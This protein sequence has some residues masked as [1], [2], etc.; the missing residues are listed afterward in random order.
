MII[1]QRK[2]ALLGESSVTP[3]LPRYTR[4]FELKNR[5]FEYSLIEASAQE[6][7]SKKAELSATQATMSPFHPR[8]KR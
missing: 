8:R 4:V 5:E 7:E 2:Y 3:S 6:L 1:M